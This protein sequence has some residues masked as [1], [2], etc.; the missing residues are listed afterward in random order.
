MKTLNRRMW[1]GTYEENRQAMNQDCVRNATSH[2]RQSETSQDS[3]KGKNTK[4]LH[5]LFIC[6]IKKKQKPCST[7]RSSY[8]PRDKKQPSWPSIFPRKLVTQSTLYTIAPGSRAVG[9][10]QDS[11]ISA[12]YHDSRL[13]L[14]EKDSNRRPPTKQC[15]QPTISSVT[16]TTA[17]PPPKQVE[18]ARAGLISAAS[19]CILLLPWASSSAPSC[20]SSLATRAISWWPDPPPRPRPTPPVATAPRLPSLSP[21]PTGFLC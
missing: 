20:S 5:A 13:P 4:P 8:N 3:R 21:W 11:S 18:A 12:C 1:R 19:D 10:K 9:C 6:V 7:P 15:R 14:T 2:R 16:R 17:P